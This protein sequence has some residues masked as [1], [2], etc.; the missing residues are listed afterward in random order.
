MLNTT[1]RQTLSIYT[2]PRSDP[3]VGWMA[4]PAFVCWAHGLCS[5]R[6]LWADLQSPELLRVWLALLRRCTLPAARLWVAQTACSPRAL[7]RGP[8][9]GACR[10]AC[11]CPRHRAPPHPRPRSTC[12]SAPPLP[13]R[14]HQSVS[15]IPCACRLTPR[16]RPFPAYYRS[17][18]VKEDRNTTARTPS[19]A[20]RKCA[21]PA[22][23]LALELV[24]SKAPQPATS[25]PSFCAAFLAAFSKQALAGVAPRC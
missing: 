24:P 4:S 7:S 19:A 5:V 1:A 13:T 20:L 8:L 18:K 25:L 10:V 14:I 15:H 16:L 23:G 2:L 6:S 11:E 9:G 17:L 21:R 3:Q 12:Q 22:S